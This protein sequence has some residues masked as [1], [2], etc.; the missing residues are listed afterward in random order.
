MYNAERLSDL[1]RAGTNPPRPHLRAPV[2][3]ASLLPRCEFDMCPWPGRR[4]CRAAHRHRGEARSLPHWMTALLPPSRRLMQRPGAARNGMVAEPSLLSSAAT[5][6]DAKLGKR[7]GVPSAHAT[8]VHF[9]GPG[10]NRAERA[11]QTP[12]RQRSRPGLGGWFVLKAPK[13]RPA[14]RFLAI[15]LICSRLSFAV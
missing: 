8:A 2:G 13:G 10:L 5:T 11:I 15:V 4:K 12:P 7:P 6:G 1:A 9:F 14:E 3:N